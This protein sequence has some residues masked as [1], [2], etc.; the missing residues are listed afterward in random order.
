[1]GPS[2]V[3]PGD[4]SGI[5]LFIPQADDKSHS[6][7]WSQKATD[8]DPGLIHMGSINNCKILISDSDLRTQDSCMWADFHPERLCR[9][10]RRDRST[11]ECTLVFMTRGLICVS[12]VTRRLSFLQDYRPQV[13]VSSDESPVPRLCFGFRRMRWPL[14]LNLSREKNQLPFGFYRFLCFLKEKVTGHLYDDK[15][16]PAYPKDFGKPGGF[17]KIIGVGSLPPRTH[18]RCLF[19]EMLSSPPCGLLVPTLA[20]GLS[21][22]SREGVLSPCQLSRAAR[23]TPMPRPLLFICII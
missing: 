23:P 9:S 12:A 4:D 22:A 7:C 3:V 17:V 1:M 11:E 21:A 13:S 5:R 16:D 20:F 15:R 19:C 18:S 6:V 14:L 2:G 10:S 8:S